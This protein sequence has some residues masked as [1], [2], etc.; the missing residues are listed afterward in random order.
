[1]LL[2][3]LCVVLSSLYYIYYFVVVVM[4]YIVEREKFVSHQYQIGYHNKG[5]LPGHIKEDSSENYHD[6]K[7]SYNILHN[8]ILL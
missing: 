4:Y 1:M 7:Y 6:S 3:V 2:L 5:S 8:M